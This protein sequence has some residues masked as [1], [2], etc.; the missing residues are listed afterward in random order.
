[1]QIGVACEQAVEFVGIGADF[2]HVT[3]IHPHIVARV[4]IPSVHLLHQ[5]DVADDK[6]LVK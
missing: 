5:C 3:H 4:G 1:M 6:S 2:V